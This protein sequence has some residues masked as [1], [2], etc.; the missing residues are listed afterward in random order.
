MA[1]TEEEITV[2][3]E[4]KAVEVIQ[5]SDADQ[6]P[7]GPQGPQGETGPAGPAGATGA[8]GDT[9][10]A[11]V[12]GAQGIQGVPGPSGTP[13]IN[14]A[15]W[16]N[17]T[18]APSNITGVDGDYSLDSTNGDYYHK[19][20]GAYVLV[21]N[22]QG[23]VGPQG[24]QGS[25]GDAGPAGATGP[26]GPQ[27]IQGVTGSTGAT[28]AAGTAGSIWRSGS[29]VPSNSSGVIND[30]YLNVD[31]GD[32]Y[33]KGAS[34]Y[35]LIGNI[36]GADGA[37]GA[38]GPTGPQG[39]AGPTGADG[40]AG[41][42]GSVWRNGN[43]VPSNTLGVDNDYYLDDVTG[44]V[45]LR[46]GG[47]Y[48]VQ[49]NIKGATGATG[50]TGSAGAAGTQG[51]QGPA[52][53]TGADG[54]AGASGVDGAA[55]SVWRSGVGSPSNG[56]GVDGDYYLNTSNGDVYLKAAGTYTVQT[57]IKGAAGATGATGAAGTPGSV[58]RSGA[59][60]PSN[61]TG[62][63]GDHY[64]N[65]TNGDVYLKGGGVYSVVAN[66]KGAD[67]AGGF[68]ALNMSLNT[69]TLG[70]V[71]RLVTSFKLPAGTYSAVASLGSSR[72]GYIAYAVIKSGSTTVATISRT[73]TLTWVSAAAL[74]TLAAETDL[75]LYIYS[76]YRG[77]YAIIKGLQIS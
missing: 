27:G 5:V 34:T 77:A 3:V 66:I 13:G 44:D 72:Y 68:T 63:D 65:Q 62:V 11:G 43:G 23:A 53:P 39:P 17:S 4:T 69:Q 33:K 51:I 8:K 1:I 67:G 74:F 49:T 61:G 30:Y 24:I 18:G 2:T 15:T 41:V 47:A 12:Q 29:G 71:P 25:T 64:L 60:A 28:G 42:V 14:G 46:S 21:G 20:G 7:V 19:E 9:G 31:N 58:W 45:Y 76:N 16:Y 26:Q 6:G 22:L 54:A 40:A 56:L 37:T 57:N 48:S 10:N 38:A 55:G 73:G 36:K 50:A 59:G 75:D 32:T 35:S 70:T 52:G